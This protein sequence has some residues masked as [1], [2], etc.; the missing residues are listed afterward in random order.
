MMPIKVVFVCLGNICRSPM[1]E[2]VFQHMVEQAG[3]S[4]RIQVDSCGTGH[5]HIGE[6]PHFGTQRTLARHGIP[7]KHRAR[8][9]CA[10]DLTEAEYLIAM[11]SE[12]L[13]SLRRVGPSKAHVALLLDFA[14]EV[15]TVDVPDPYY[16]G[17][18]D[19]VYDLVVRGCQ[20]LL[21]HIREK[22][23]F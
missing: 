15:E 10:A 2:G 19:E 14:K 17:R 18:F 1:A 9:L 4:D 8:Q 23:G 5:W 7:Y 6:E 20:G 16:N 13:S 11:D 21:A 22:E 12:N 3:L